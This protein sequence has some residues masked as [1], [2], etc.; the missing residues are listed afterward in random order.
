MIT[1]NIFETALPESQTALWTPNRLLCVAHDETWME[2]FS[3][4][5]RSELRGQSTGKEQADT[6]S[7]IINTDSDDSS[8]GDSEA[9]TSEEL[10]IS[11]A[12]T[13]I[14]SGLTQSD[15]IEPAPI[16]AGRKQSHSQV[17]IEFPQFE[18]GNHATEDEDIS[19]ESSTTRSAMDEIE[20]GMNHAESE[21]VERMIKI[22]DE[23]RTHTPGSDKT[24][25]PIQ[26]DADETTDRIAQPNPELG[27]ANHIGEL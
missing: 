24:S 11:M 27:L 22:E 25:T 3:N 15:I 21:E 2:S 12:A 1:N 23:Q 17:R 7:P 20:N 16:A 19:M 6:L 13:P 5:L 10:V 14:P 9:G 26:M 8:I 4:S 18:R